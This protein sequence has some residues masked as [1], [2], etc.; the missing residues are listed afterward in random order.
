MKKRSAILMAGLLSLAMVTA[1]FGIMMS[2]TSPS[3]AGGRVAIATRRKP[4]V[5]TVTQRRTVHVPAL[6]GAAP[7]AATSSV[8]PEPDPVPAPDPAE[9]DESS[10]STQASNDPG[11]EPV[12]QESDAPEPAGTESESESPEPQNPEQQGD[13]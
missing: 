8:T 10:G 2:F 4:V 6:G 3:E 12:E 7:A 9:T 5:K 11:N 13:D 1:A